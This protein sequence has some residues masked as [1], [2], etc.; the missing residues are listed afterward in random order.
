MKTTQSLSAITSLT[1]SVC[2]AIVAH[3]ALAQS[4]AAKPAQQCVTDLKAF[5]AL[6]QKDGYWLHA[7]GYGYGYPMYGYGYGYAMQPASPAGGFSRVRPGYDVRTLMASA[8]S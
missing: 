6:L 1:A 4:A 5:E 7:S 3:S 2:L 8:M